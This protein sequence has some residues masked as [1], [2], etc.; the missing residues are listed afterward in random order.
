MGLA[1][2]S[3]CGVQGKYY[4]FS[5]TLRFLGGKMPAPKRQSYIAVG[6]L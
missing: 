1:M 2:Y 6:A 3:Y 5:E 4:I